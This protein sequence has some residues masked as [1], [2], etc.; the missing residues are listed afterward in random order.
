MVAR[1]FTR[2]VAPPQLILS[3][4]AGVQPVIPLGLPQRF[5]DTIN[6]SLVYTLL[7]SAIPVTSNNSQS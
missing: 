3:T 7:R 1:R 6:L 2:L 4:P 5:N